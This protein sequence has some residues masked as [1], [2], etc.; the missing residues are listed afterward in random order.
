MKKG[1]LFLLFTIRA[2]I[3]FAQYESL[4]S[5]N[6]INLKGTLSDKWSFFAEGQVR[7]LKYYD[8]FHY[9]EFKS[10]LTFEVNKFFRVSLATGKYDT[11]KEGGD[12][13]LPKNNDEFRIWPQLFLVQ[14]LGKFIIEQRGRVEMRF[15]TNSH[16]NRFR[17]RLGVSYPFGKNTQG[18]KPFQLSVSNEIFFTDNEPYFERNRFFLSANYRISTLFS[19]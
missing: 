10:G 8:D 16:R 19:T 5:W 7:S 9:H 13:V 18:F 6:I 11:Y 12:F 1:I 4:G 17:Y 14:P 2:V 15:S 3:I